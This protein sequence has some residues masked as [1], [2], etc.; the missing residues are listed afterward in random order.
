MTEKSSHMRAE[1]DETGDAL[2]QCV[3]PAANIYVNFSLGLEVVRAIVE[4]T[5]A[6]RDLPRWLTTR[7]P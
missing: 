6:R 7:S 1:I 4:R 5:I 2:A 3:G